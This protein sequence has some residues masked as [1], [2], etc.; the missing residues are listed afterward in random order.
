MG[1]LSSVWDIFI[2][3]ILVAVHGFC[4][5]LTVGVSLF[6]VELLEVL[7]FSILRFVDFVLL[8]V[9]A[10]HSHKGFFGLI[11]L[12]PANLLWENNFKH[13]EEVAILEGIFVVG[14]TFF[15]NG[16]DLFRLDYLAFLRFHSEFGSVEVVN[17]EIDTAKRFKEG[18]LLGH[19]KIGT[20]PLEGLVLLLG[21]DE[22]DISGFFIG[23]LIRF[24]VEV[25]LL[26]IWSTLTDVA[27][28]YFFLFLENFFVTFLDKPHSAD[29]D[30]GLFA[31]VKVFQSAR[32]WMDY[33]FG[34]FRSHFGILPKHSAK[35]VFGSLATIL[36]DGF[37]TIFVVGGSFLWVR[38]SVVSLLDIQELFFVSTF[39]WMLLQA[40][41]PV[42]LLDLCVVGILINTK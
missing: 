40:L 19:E 14:H 29:P 32:N 13:D 26:A 33:R 2:I 25:K 41:L 36:F 7:H 22:H 30:L 21:N 10:F 24:A 3:F 16:H 5:S 1:A 17:N 15:F 6:D 11:F 20:S 12:V 27:L 4:A 28:N 18:D 9:H 34:T 23:M 31:V 39:I 42:S 38:K 35:N 37:L 8:W